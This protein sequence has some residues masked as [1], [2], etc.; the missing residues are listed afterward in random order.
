MNFTDAL[1]RMNELADLLE[2]SS[3]SEEEAARLFEEATTLI[4]QGD[5]FLDDVEQRLK[6]MKAGEGEGA[7]IL[8]IQEEEDADRTRR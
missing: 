8:S 2:E 4:E 1:S 3:L 6:E 7:Y 5:S